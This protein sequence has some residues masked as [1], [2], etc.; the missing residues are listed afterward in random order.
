MCFTEGNKSKRHYVEAMQPSRRVAPVYNAERWETPRKAPLVPPSPQARKKAEAHVKQALRDAEKVES[1]RHKKRFAT[2]NTKA[3][4]IRERALATA[5]ENKARAPL[6]LPPMARPVVD[7][8]D[9]FAYPAPLNIRKRT[10][11]QQQQ[12][13]QRPVRRTELGNTTPALRNASSS[14]RPTDHHQTHIHPALRDTV[15]PAP[16]IHPALRNL[17]ATP[18]RPRRVSDQSQSS[19]ERNVYSYL[20]NPLN[21]ANSPQE[22]G[23]LP[24]NV[25]QKVPYTS[26]RRGR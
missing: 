12:Q 14:S 2:S 18:A 4:M 15:W 24:V 16:E 13:Q 9:S 10:P 19:I 23:V 5:K 25:T 6:P 26:S 17:P 8:D 3:D 7:D 1:N 22:S 11:Q 20:G 21:Y